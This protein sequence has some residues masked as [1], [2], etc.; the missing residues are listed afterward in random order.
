M[1]K[2]MICQYMSNQRVPSLRTNN[3]KRRCLCSDREVISVMQVFIN[4]Q[5]IPQ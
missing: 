3:C 1:I 2:T 5:R 4:P